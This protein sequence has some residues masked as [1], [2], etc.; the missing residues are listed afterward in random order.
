[1]LHKFLG[2]RSRVAILPLLG[3]SLCLA[4]AANAG[5]LFTGADI[6]E[7]MGLTTDRIGRFNT[8]GPNVL[9]G[10]V[11]VSP[12]FVNGMTIMGD[13]LV[14][15]TVGTAFTTA[16]DGQTI[17]FRDL[18]GVEQSSVVSP[19]LRTDAFNEDWAFHD[20]F[21]WR[22]H[23]DSSDLGDIRQ[24]DP[25][26]L[27]GP[28]VAVFDLEFGAVGATSAAGDLWITDWFGQTVGTFDTGLGIYTAIFSTSGLG[29]AGGLA[30][31]RLGGVL[32][33]GTSGGQ[34]TPFSLAGVQLGP[35]FLPFGDIGPDTIDGLAFFVPEPGTAVLF[36]L[37][38][39]G[40]GL[41]RRRRRK[42]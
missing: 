28:P 2:G 37:G 6:E 35:S 16:A 26:N 30:Y 14:T 41:N 23:F 22:S 4:S 39:V 12:T 33:V 1:M 11:I 34:V 32:W 8:S 25:N 31:D 7:F 21:L 27:G 38:L 15:G 20:G 9:G 5:L 18:N 40:V 13:E 3:L 10:G 19:A 29:N 42:A 36:G 17:R 24:L